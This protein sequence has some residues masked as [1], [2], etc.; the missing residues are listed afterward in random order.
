MRP[1]EPKRGI[2]QLLSPTRL[3]AGLSLGGQTA[4][5]PSDAGM[6]EKYQSIVDS[7]GV[8]ICL[9]NRDLRIEAV[10][11]QIKSWYPLVDFTQKPLLYDVIDVERV[12]DRDCLPTQTFTDGLPHRE[13]RQAKLAGKTQ[14]LNFA[15]YPIKDKRGRVIG[16]SCIT[17]DVT[18]AKNDAEQQTEQL[19]A[20]ERKYLSLIQYSSDGIFVLDMKTHVILEANEQFLQMSGYSATEIK[21]IKLDDIVVNSELSVAENISRALRQTGAVIG[22]RRYRRKDGSV[23]ES[24]AS[25]VVIDDAPAQVCLVT[26]RDVTEKLATELYLQQSLTKLRETLQETV[27]ALM[28]VAEKKDPYTAGHHQRVA[29]LAGAI[30]AEMGLKPQ[31]IDAL[32]IAGRLHDIGKINIPTDILNKPG[33]LTKIEM[34]IIKTHP[35]VSYEIIQKIPFEGPVATIVA[36]HH[37]KLDGSGYPQGLQGDNILLEAKILCVADVVEAMASHR[38][39]RPAVGLPQALAE[40]NENKGKLYDSVVVD[41]CLHLFNEGFDLEQ[42]ETTK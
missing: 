34:S 7:L 31:Q 32:L 18:R 28:T 24:E 21:Q 39:Y 17:E 42:P 41:V 14:Y 9:I 20:S 29:R 22:V 25:L 5:A 27:N 40:I 37:E 6:A 13:V 10:N 1:K 8:G 11:C 2:L 36:Q 16:V 4:A 30:A 35:Q 15:T 19:R 26:V 38:P 3:L 33:K 12:N 23:L